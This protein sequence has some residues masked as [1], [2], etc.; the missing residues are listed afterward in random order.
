MRNQQRYGLVLADTHIQPWKSSW[1]IWLVYRGLLD[2]WLCDTRSTD[3]Y[4][5]SSKPCCSHACHLKEN[6]FFLCPLLVHV[7]H[8][9]WQVN[10]LQGRSSKITLYMK[11]QCDVMGMVWESSQHDCPPSLWDR[12]FIVTNPSFCFVCVQ[13]VTFLKEKTAACD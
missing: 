4:L 7:L 2:F 9:D 8:W 10:G 11:M 1:A 12:L 6:N 3:L 13:Y 5:S